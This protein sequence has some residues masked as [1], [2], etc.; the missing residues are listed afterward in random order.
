[1]WL[2]IKDREVWWM[3]YAMTS[4]VVALSFNGYFPTLSATMG[5]NPTVTL[6]ISAPPFVFTAIMTFT[7]FRSVH[8]NPK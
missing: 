1:M 8:V 7:V 2:A 4:Q 6:L 5:F 3:A